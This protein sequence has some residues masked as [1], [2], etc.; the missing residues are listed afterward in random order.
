MV[1]RARD[2]VTGQLC[3][4]KIIDKKELVKST[5]SV[6]KQEIEILK[7][8]V[9]ARHA[10]G[11]ARAIAPT[12]DAPVFASFAALLIIRSFALSLFV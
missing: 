2:V 10:G 5:A 12:R 7:A 3:A 11:Q 8:V 4:V 1:R 6:V 9:S